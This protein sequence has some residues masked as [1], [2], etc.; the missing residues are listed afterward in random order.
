VAKR[1]TELTV[2]TMNKK[3]LLLS[4]CSLTAPDT[5]QPTNSWSITDYTWC[6]CVV[7]YCW[8]DKPHRPS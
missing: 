2:E 8:N 1:K 4:R 7:L 5:L 6:C 3:L